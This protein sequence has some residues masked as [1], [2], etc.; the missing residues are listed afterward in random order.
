MRLSFVAH[1]EIDGEVN[2]KAL[3]KALLQRLKSPEDRIR[4]LSSSILPEHSPTREEKIVR[5]QYPRCKFIPGSW[6]RL[7]YED[8]KNR[9][10]RTQGIILNL[11]V[12]MLH[13]RK[14]DAIKEIPIAS[15]VKVESYAPP[16]IVEKWKA[17]ES[18]A[19]MIKRIME[20]EKHLHHITRY[21]QFLLSKLKGSEA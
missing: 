15:I 17:I 2:P 11:P 16:R 5:F 20:Q 19:L 4:V 9:Q 14:D 13:N 10:R 3:H 21:H 1:L 12:L 18:A 6:I 7:V 8:S